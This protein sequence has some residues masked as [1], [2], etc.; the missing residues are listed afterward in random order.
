MANELGK[1]WVDSILNSVDKEVKVCFHNIGVP[2]PL[3]SGKNRYSNFGTNNFAR[4]VLLKW[5]LIQQS[6]SENDSSFVVFSD[7]DVVWMQSPDMG[8]IFFKDPTKLVAF[9]EDFSDKG[10]KFCTGIMIWKNTAVAC[11][12]LEDIQKY[13]LKLL[14]TNPLA[15]DENAVNSWAKRNTEKEFFYY[16]NRY[17]YVIGHKIISLILNLK[18]YS[19]KFF[20]AVHANYFLGLNQKFHILN[21]VLKS[22]SNSLDLIVAVLRIYLFKL[23]NQFVRRSL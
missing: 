6:L 4:S 17:Q 10:S 18:P 1:T 21:L 3:S 11:K 7:L 22:N 13:N 15:T 20:T 5:E 12:I 2:L 14:E 16:L 8:D 19:F 9:Q 23:K